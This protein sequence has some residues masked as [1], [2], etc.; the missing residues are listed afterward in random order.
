MQKNN[1]TSPKINFDQAVSQ[2]SS[3]IRIPSVSAESKH[4]NNVLACANWLVHHLK[5]TGLQHVQLI[6][7]K[8]HPVV[9]ADWM[10][11]PGKPVL[12]IYGH[13]D[14]QPADPLKE[15]TENPFSGA[16]KNGF[17]YGR[18]A[19]DDKGQMFAHIKALEYFLQANKK[20]PINIKCV[21]EGEE[22]T[23]S[24]GLQQLL[25]DHPVFFK[26]DAAVIS[27]MSIPSPV[28]PAITTSL[29]GMLSFE[30]E[31][32][33][34]K[35][36][37]HSGT[38]GGAVHNPAHALCSI[39]AALHNRQ[40]RITIPGFYDKVLQLSIAQ[41]QS[42]K[43]AGRSDEK[44]L[45]DAGAECGYG[46]DGYSLYE[47]IA[48]RPSLSVNGI[49]TGYQ[50]EGPK[51]II[52]SVAKAKMSFR[53]VANQLPDEVEILFRNYIKSIAPK[54][55]KVL[56]KKNA[57]ANPVLINSE[58]IF[59]KAAAIAYEK[60]FKNQTAFLGSGGTIPI[61]N[62]LQD[63]LHMPV[64]LMGFALPDDNPHGPNE[65]MSLENFYKGIMT[66][67]EFINELGKL[68]KK[69]N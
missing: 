46:E 48:I 62:L 18:G 53:L 10:D 26:A 6:K 45:A 7:T 39:I 8:K 20:I 42:M 27:D 1:C 40:G 54:C 15:W 9:Y 33:G 31:V 65:K 51:S 29:R 64:V 57:A 68:Q 23:G 11:A 19:S 55:I 22:E 30:L 69:I 67:I 60:V 63:L 34:Q 47:N 49:T 52:P 12:L 37:L 28:Q 66:S 32:R 50:G 3:F 36:D 59:I 17:I 38:F 44:I 41:Q 13:Y 61:V 2:L 16:V 24:E 58:N 25:K 5:Q 43:K 21:F 4:S 35:T 56:I 14:V